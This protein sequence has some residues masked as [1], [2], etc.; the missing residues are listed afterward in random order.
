MSISSSVGLISGLPIDDLI[1]TYLLASQK[2]I[3]SLQSRQSGFQAAQASVIDINNALLNLRRAAETLS[4]RETY[5]ATSA[6][7]S[8]DSAFAATS[9]A[10]ASLG[11]HSIEIL[12]LASAHRI[13]AQG[14][15]DTDTTAVASA[16]GFF[17]FKVGTSG[18]A[19]SI[20]V[21][22]T[23]TLADLRNAIN[24]LDAGVTA[25]IIND[26][27]GTNAYRLVLTSDESGSSNS[28]I[29]VQ[30]DTS[31][32]F[33]NKVIEEAAAATGNT[34]AGAI[35]SSGT[36]TG[37]ESKQYVIEIT[38]AGDLGVAK[39]RVS[40]DGGVT[41]GPDSEFTTSGT[42]VD[43]G[44]GVMVDFSA[45]TFAVGD[46]FTVDAFAPV[47]SQAKNAVM[48]IDGITLVRDSNTVDD[49]I[50][51]LSLD[52]HAVTSSAE[53]VSVSRSVATARVQ[54]NSFVE[55][56]NEVIEQ[57]AIATAFDQETGVRGALLGDSSVRNIQST[58]ASTITSVIPGLPNSEINSLAGIG[59]SVTDTGSLRFDSSK[60]E[61]ALANDMDS[62]EKIFATVGTS[63]SSK[64][65]FIQAS[66]AT[67]PGNYN[68][69]ISVLAEQAYVLSNQDITGPITNEEHLTFTV[70]GKDHIVTV[71]A[72]LT[73]E[74]AIET[75]N[76]QLD[77]DGI[78]FVASAEGN[79]LRLASKDYGSKQSISVV[80]DQSGASGTQLGIGTTVRTD[81][82]L[83]VQGT[84]GGQEA[85]GV[86]Q[87]LTG[88]DGTT[89][90][91]LEI[92]VTATTTGYVGTLT[93]STGI[94][95]QLEEI[96]DSLTDSE[97]GILT[98]RQEGLTDSIDD[99]NDQI[100]AIQDRMEREETRL[101]SQFASL[102]VLLAQMNS[103][104]SFLTQ[105]LSSLASLTNSR[106]SKN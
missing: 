9:S 93:I 21:N 22:A 97:D 104:S 98:S 106:F 27:S 58:L 48:K 2:K 41:F 85:T 95:I 65:D 34:Y 31:L 71:A 44:D 69:E 10:G 86:G 73:L 54:I 57:I 75:I 1:A 29:M 51:G 60:F 18:V 19:K 35:T 63:S 56:Y 68:V 61:E 12:Q 91:G 50:D 30:N 20:A 81:T 24:Q 74:E 3:S 52:L 72:G 53:S 94:G 84:I 66:S 36:F 76:E 100:T 78:G 6:F 87:T 59:I 88:K 28:I 83:D 89:A 102:E 32:D 4:D 79:Q 40:T 23:T 103:T 16:D 15:A 62:V 11:S 96:L 38:E 7:A 46:T 17:S 14:Y 49:A 64:L 42:A 13:G 39:F 77:E 33:T 105:Q 25:S 99:I 47:I 92:L 55:Q 8:D 90:E 37:A 26:G 67:V 70:D 5:R 101:R 45:G 80:S 82:G 43:I